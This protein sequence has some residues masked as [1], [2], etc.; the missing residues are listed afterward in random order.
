MSLMLSSTLSVLLFAGMQMYRQQL[1]AQE[2]MTVV[3]GFIG[4]IL[5]ILVLT[6]SFKTRLIFL[7]WTL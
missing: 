1:A 4:S 6:V 3:G 5:F 2:G 7:P